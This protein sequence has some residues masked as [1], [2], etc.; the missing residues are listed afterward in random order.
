MFKLLDQVPNGIL[1]MLRDLE[2][3]I[4]NAGLADMMASANIITQVKFEFTL[5]YFF[6]HLIINNTVEITIIII[7]IIY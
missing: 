1:K 2:I 7:N 3:Y 5:I 4:I 6:L